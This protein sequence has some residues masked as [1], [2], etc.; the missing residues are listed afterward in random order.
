M[1]LILK[2]YLLI[3]NYLNPKVFKKNVLMKIPI[4][5]SVYIKENKCVQYSDTVNAGSSSEKVAVSGD[6]KSCH[7]SVNI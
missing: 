6:R 4:K 2:F 1:V 7:M 3:D 5:I